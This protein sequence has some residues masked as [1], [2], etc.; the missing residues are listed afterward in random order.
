PGVPL[1]ARGQHAVAA[2][3]AERRRRGPRPRR[4]PLLGAPHLGTLA[5]RALPP[6]RDAA[7]HARDAEPGPRRRP[8][9]RRL[10]VPRR[11]LPAP[12]HVLRRAPQQGAGGIA[13]VAVG[14]PPRRARRQRRPQADAA[15]AG[16]AKGQPPRHPALAAHHPLAAAPALRPPLRGRPPGRPQ[17]HLPLPARGRQG[18][19]PLDA[20][21]A[22]R[23]HQ[24]PRRRPHREAVRHCLVR[25]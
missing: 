10:L 21:P 7:D 3:A 22:A 4:P 15:P 13:A 24:G 8:A 17:L 6:A 25:R 18:P 23:Q 2:A 9:P 11:P 19:D 5:R 14:A 12:R 20:R 1:P 16:H